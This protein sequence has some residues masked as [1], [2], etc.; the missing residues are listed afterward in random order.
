[1]AREYFFP[2]T[3]F[4]SFFCF[5][6]A[7]G[8]VQNLKTDQ[9]TSGSWALSWDPQDESLCQTDEYAIEYALTNRDQCE[10]IGD[11]DRV[12]FPNVDSEMVEINGLKSFSTY[13]AFVIP[14]NDYG[15]GEETFEVGN[16]TEAGNCTTI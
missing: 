13:M 14:K 3:D 8:P 7:L 9:I 12:L 11:P 10:V 4:I 2:T 16:T 1:M 6:V 15:R 5:S